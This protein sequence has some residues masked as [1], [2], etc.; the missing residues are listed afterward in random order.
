MKKL[1]TLGM[2]V[3]VLANML[4]MASAAHVETAA[5]ALLTADSVP[6]YIETM[7]IDVAPASEEKV[8]LISSMKSNR[9]LTVTK[10]GCFYISDSISDLTDDDNLI[11]DV[12]SDYEFAN[13]AIADGILAIDKSS[14]ELYNLELTKSSLS[15]MKANAV[16]RQEYQIQ[17]SMMAYATH[18][19]NPSLY[20][21][22]MVVSNRATITR[23]YNEMVELEYTNPSISPGWATTMFWVGKVQ[24]GGPWDYKLIKNLGPWD[25]VYCCTYGYR[26]TK[27][28]QHRNAEFIGNYNYGYTG[29]D[30]FSL[31]ILKKG[32]DAAAGKIWVADVDD[33]PAIE[34]GYYDAGR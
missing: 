22:G 2:A 28:N 33:Y 3:A 31:Y 7:P 18:C 21:S 14:L 8:A 23:Y 10:D 16:K 25:K 34:E 19:S 9:V 4:I 17:N 26:D 5:D 6:K 11:A 20:L 27:V 15:K 24:A 1:L 29:R 12:R 32:S 30:L 13:Q